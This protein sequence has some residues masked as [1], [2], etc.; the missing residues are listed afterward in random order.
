MGFHISEELVD[1]VLQHI[2][3][4]IGKAEVLK[5]AQRFIDN[6]KILSVLN[7][8]PDVEFQSSEDVKNALNR[9]GIWKKLG[10]S[11]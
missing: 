9:V 6:E 11:R 3:Y 5:V 2:P 8:L 7:S 10:G 4:P 1:Q